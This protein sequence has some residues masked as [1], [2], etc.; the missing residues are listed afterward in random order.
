MGLLHLERDITSRDPLFLGRSIYSEFN[1]VQ[2]SCRFFTSILPC[3]SPP[4]Q[5]TINSKNIKNQNSKFKNDEKSTESPSSIQLQVKKHFTHTLTHTI[6]KRRRPPLAPAAPPQ[7]PASR[8]YPPTP[9]PPTAATVPA[10]N[11]CS[12]PPSAPLAHRRYPATSSG[13]SPSRP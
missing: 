4:Y 1:T 7:S 8:P 11:S 5:K 10:P 6:L 12:R 9:C 13:P 2:G 3:C